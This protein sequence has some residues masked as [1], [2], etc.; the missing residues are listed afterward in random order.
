MGRPAKC[1]F[2][3]KNIETKD[4][5]KVINGKQVLYFCNEEHYQEFLDKKEAER[6]AREEEKKCAKEKKLKKEEAEKQKRKEDKNK[7]YYL[8]CDIVGRKEIINT[9]LWKEWK[10]WNKVATNE[11]IGQYLEENKDYL[12]KVISRIENDEFKRIRYLSAILKNKLGNY[13][14]KSNVINTKKI[15][16]CEESYSIEK[17]KYKKQNVR[18]GLEIFE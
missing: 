11:V 9:V 16:E 14:P 3:Q 12:I 10:I 2:C 7:V 8:I 5:H 1:R 4:A 6:I 15:I 17:P 13:K 18:V